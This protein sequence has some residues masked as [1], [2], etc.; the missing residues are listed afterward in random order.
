MWTWAKGDSHSERP[1]R[2]IKWETL[3]L[4]RGERSACRGRKLPLPWNPRE[5]V[6]LCGWEVSVHP[7]IGMQWETR[8][9]ILPV[10]VATPRQVHLQRRDQHQHGLRRLIWGKPDRQ[11]S[12][13][14]QTGERNSACKMEISLPVP[15]GGRGKEWQWE[16]GR[17]EDTKRKTQR[18][19]TKKPVGRG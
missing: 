5:N 13:Q 6:F 14:R 9:T 16:K 3:R 17:S 10:L 2:G 8:N 7:A 12:G 4:G 15:R 18:L 11:A 1:Q 19:E